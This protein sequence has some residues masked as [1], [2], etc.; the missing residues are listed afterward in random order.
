[1]W[2]GVLT[3]VFVAWLLYRTPF[4]LRVRAAGEHPLL[5]PRRGGECRGREGR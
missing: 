4:G 3:V 1:V 5:Q 2:L